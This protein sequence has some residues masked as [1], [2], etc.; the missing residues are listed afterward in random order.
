MWTFRGRAQA[1]IAALGA[2][3]IAPRAAR[4]EDKA[5]AEVVPSKAPER[6]VS[7]DPKQS[8]PAP[9]GRTTF[10]IDP[11][12]DS[13][14]IA[15]SLGFAGTLELINST[16][17]IRPQQIA[18]NFNTSNLIGIDRFAVTRQPTPSAGTTSSAA[19]IVALAYAVIDPVLSGVR[20]KSVQTG[21]ADAFMYAEALSFTL[22]MTNV[23]KIA[24][25]RPRPIAYIEADAH[26]DDPDYANNN[27]DSALSFF[28]S[29]AAITA[30]VS[31]TATYLAFARAPRTARPWITLAM[32]VGLTTFVS[33]ER[34]RA[35]QHFPTD[36]IAG[37]IAGAGIGLV[38]PHL[39]RTDDI[40][41]RRIWVGFNPLN[42]HHGEQGGLL[43]VGGIF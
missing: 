2:L 8:E 5:T 13:A 30:T 1:F 34:V 35:G 27:T 7:L 40:K 36:V 15:V 38:V 24:V 4:A 33:I 29:H 20:E 26:K 23:V 9:P 25:R 11:V 39:H 14:M 37:S 17:E 19:V 21:V 6:K 41:Q 32:G 43:N 3:A 42:S 16:G 28:S 31:A 22:A 10:D 12:A 18:P